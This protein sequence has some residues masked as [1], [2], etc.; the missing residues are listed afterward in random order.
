VVWLV[1]AWMAFV[2]WRECDDPQTLRW[3]RRLKEIVREK[4]AGARAPGRGAPLGRRRARAAQLTR[5]EPREAA[6][7]DG[8]REFAG[9]SNAGF[10]VGSAKRK[11]PRHERP[12]FRARSDGLDSKRW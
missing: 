6:V 7:P 10:D 12:G 11:A 5:T 4:T 8:Y 9:R 3:E 1:L 2:Y